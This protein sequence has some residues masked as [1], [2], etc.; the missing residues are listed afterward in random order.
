MVSETV[1]CNVLLLKI[2]VLGKKLRNLKCTLYP[3][4]HPQLLSCRHLETTH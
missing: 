3:K 2:T 1:A 4:L